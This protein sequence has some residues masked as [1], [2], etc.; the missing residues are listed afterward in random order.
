MKYFLAAKS[1]EVAWKQAQLASFAIK[2]SLRPLFGI[3]VLKAWN[4]DL[5]EVEAEL[6]CR[7]KS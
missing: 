5:R 2:L 1:A 7:F 6:V 3:A 4:T